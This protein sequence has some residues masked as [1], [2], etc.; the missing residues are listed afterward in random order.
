MNSGLADQIRQY[1]FYRYAELTHPND[2]WVID[3]SPMHISSKQNGYQLETV[4]GL[5]PNLL[6]QQFDDDIWKYMLDTIISKNI[7]MPQLL[8]QNGM[9]DLIMITD[10]MDNYAFDGTILRMSPSAGFHPRVLDIN[11]NVYYHAYYGTFSYFNEYREVFLKELAF[12]EIVDENNLKY[13]KMILEAE[14]PTAIH[15]RR[16]DFLTVNRYAG[17]KYFKFAMTEMKKV[18]PNM[19]LFVFSDDMRYCKKNQQ[20][21]GLD[22]SEQIIFVEGNQNC[23]YEYRDCQLMSYCQNFILCG[24]GFSALAVQISHNVNFIFGLDGI[25]H[26]YAN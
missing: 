2:D 15:I 23:E 24:S 7:L 26:K 8:R 3:D 9:N 20:R 11:G 12:P 16:G 5:K 18:I 6:S 4:F 22:L 14:N 19:T 17:D 1:S 13:K 10:Q 25:M 21:L